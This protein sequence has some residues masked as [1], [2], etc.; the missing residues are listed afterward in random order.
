MY[1]FPH[2]ENNASIPPHTISKY[3]QL[4]ANIVRNNFML[5]LPIRLMVSV[6]VDGK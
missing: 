2:V 1:E 4:L 6:N 3:I 5:L